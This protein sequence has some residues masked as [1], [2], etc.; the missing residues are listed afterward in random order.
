MFVMDLSFINSI[1][2]TASVILLSAML[3]MR[4]EH[5]AACAAVVPGFGLDRLG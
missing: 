4:I 2:A 5:T 3:I 1:S